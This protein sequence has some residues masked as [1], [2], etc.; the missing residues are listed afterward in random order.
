MWDT[1]NSAY[2]IWFHL[3]LV[4]SRSVIKV[5]CVSTLSCQ[6]IILTSFKTHFINS[7]TTTPLSKLLIMSTDFYFIFFQPLPWGATAHTDIWKIYHFFLLCCVFV[8][9]MF[10]PSSLLSRDI[11][12]AFHLYS[13]P[14]KSCLPPPFLSSLCL[15]I[16]FPILTASPSNKLS[17]GGE[18]QL[19]HYMPL[20]IFLLANLN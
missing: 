12:F 6:I 11:H 18:P 19:T 8:G 15:F 20:K 9:E 10:F 13:M 2:D 17:G 16:L 5:V 14:L 7:F 1:H 3:S 4:A